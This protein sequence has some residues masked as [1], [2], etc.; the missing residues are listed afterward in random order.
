LWGVNP[1]NGY[2]GVA[3]GTNDVT[4][5]NAMDAMSKNSIFTNVALTP[6][7]D[8]WWEGKTDQLPE[9]LMD[10][11]K[12]EWTPDCGRKAAHPN[13]R[14]TVPQR[15]NPCLDPDF[16][17]SLGVP[18]DALIFGGRRSQLIPLVNESFSWNHGVFQASLCSSETT[19]AAV[20]KVGVVRRDPMAMLPF[21]GYN[22]AYYWQHWIDI[23]KKLSNPPK[24]FY[25]NW[26]RKQE[27]KFIWPGFG[28][29]IRVLEWIC[30]CV[31]GKALVKSI[32]PQGYCPQYSSMNFDGLKISKEKFKELTTIDTK[33]DK[34]LWASEVND[35]EAFYSRFGSDLPKELKKE[36]EDWSKRLNIFGPG[37]NK[38]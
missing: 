6:E 34:D 24:I 4:N 37:N 9:K 33:R 38:K 2:F 23:G 35:C 26:F 32:T 13:S 19:A 8:V 29:N 20:G 17:N 25:V 28:E 30:S 1:E 5:R 36:F 11:T 10:W 7:G 22:M 12:K 21:C 14:Y 16:E 27:G 15:Q 18:I 31:D 3:P